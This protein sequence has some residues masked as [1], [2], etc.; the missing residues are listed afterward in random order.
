VGGLDGSHGEDK[1]FALGLGAYIPLE[2]G[3]LD[4]P[5][6]FILCGDCRCRLIIKST[7]IMRTF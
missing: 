3:M 7:Q 4:M 2:G 5:Q 1:C 6:T